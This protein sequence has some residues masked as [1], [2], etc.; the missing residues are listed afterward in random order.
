MIASRDITNF[1]GLGV[2]GWSDNTPVVMLSRCL[3]S[4]VDLARS[5]A[6]MKILA[7]IAKTFGMTD[8]AW[9][10]HANPW[11]VYTRFAAIL[12]MI[13]AAWSRVWIGWWALL[14]VA[15]AIVCLW[16]NPHIFPAV[17]TPRS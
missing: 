6:K 3:G 11:S 9:Q 5:E 10:R 14:P 15:A 8:E 16:L 17:T 4:L 2:P 1:L 12:L 7:Q 13:L